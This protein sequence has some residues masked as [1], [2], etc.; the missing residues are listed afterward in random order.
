MI[1]V[2]C[3]KQRQSVCARQSA[4]IDTVNLLLCDECSGKQFEPRHLI[5]IVGRSKGI[6]RVRDYIISHKY[7]GPDITAAELTT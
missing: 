1:C 4:L 3:G 2:S 6:D 5:V 7:V